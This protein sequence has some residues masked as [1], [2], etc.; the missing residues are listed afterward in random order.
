MADIPLYRQS[1]G[2]SC[3]PAAMMMV[4][5][6]IHRNTILD[7][8][9]ELDIWRES[10]LMESKATSAFGLALAARMKGY[11]VKVQ[12]DSG[13]IGF[14]KR[15]KEH[16]PHID[17]GFMEM[18]H[19]HTREKAIENGVK[20]D[21]RYLELKDIEEDVSRG[22]KPIVLISSKMMRELIGIPHYVVV[23]GFDEKHVTIANPET[24][25]I[26]R[27][28]RKRFEKYLGYRGYRSMISVIK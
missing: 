16:F 9:L 13:E 19:S 8:D 18:L 22:E 6:S 28:T 2:F 12:T 23:T 7:R 1:F 24:A 10:T 15:L 4:M 20:W 26:E 27:Y 25:R 3:G 14:T 11:N 5:G 21:R 17:L